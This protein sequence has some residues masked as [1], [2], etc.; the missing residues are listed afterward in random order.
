MTDDDLTLTPVYRF[1]WDDGT[2]RQTDDHSVLA[3]H[4]DGWTPD[5]VEALAALG[6]RD[7]NCTV[8]LLGMEN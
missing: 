1:E 5:S 6:R 2:V 8:K 3:Y 4:V 7:P